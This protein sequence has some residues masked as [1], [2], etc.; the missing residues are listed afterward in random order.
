MNMR[1]IILFSA[2]AAA[3]SLGA[4]NAYAMGGG[5]LA[6]EESPYA[7]L[8]PQTIGPSWMNEG[9]SVYT[10]P[11]VDS[12]AQTAPAIENPIRHKRHHYHQY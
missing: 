4:V 11:D 3:V 2:T 10:G 1:K 8:A 12:G 7:I 5:N 6:P 9:R